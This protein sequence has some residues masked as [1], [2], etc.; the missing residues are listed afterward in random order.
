MD[1]VN[2]PQDKD[3]RLLKRQT[4]PYCLTIYLPLADATDGTNPSRI[5]LKNMLRKAKSQLKT[6][7]MKSLDIERSLAPMSHLLD[8]SEFWPSGHMFG[9]ALFGHPDFFEVYHLPNQSLKQQISI[10]TSFD[11]SQLQQYLDSDKSYFVLTL[12][13]KNVRL[14]E[15]N[16]NELKLVKLKGLPRNLWSALKIDEFPKWLE[17]HTVAPAASG[18]GSEA[19]HG[20]YNVKETDKIMLYEFLRRIDK[21]LRQFFRGVQAPLVLGGVDH[22]VSAYR[23]VG[24]YPN[25]LGKS[26][27]GNLNDTPKHV[28]HNSA[29][30]IVNQNES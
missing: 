2:I 4:Y 15:G 6:A 20:Q 3:L 21:R 9:L 30:R 10:D 11:L 23:R 25:T 8:S 27:K 19:Y 28:I 24:T 5:E 1:D 16:R 26:I 17:T 12:D 29:W 18:K 13:H 14:F 7:G 22:I